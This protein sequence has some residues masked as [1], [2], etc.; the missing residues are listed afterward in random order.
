MDDAIHGF[1]NAWMLINWQA[2]K[3]VKEAMGWF[4]KA[5]SY[6]VLDGMVTD[7]IGIKQV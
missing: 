7:H 6:F 4:E 5:L 2:A 3:I 1:Q